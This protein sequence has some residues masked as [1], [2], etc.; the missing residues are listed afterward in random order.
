MAANFHSTINQGES[1]SECEH[2]WR[3]SLYK[4]YMKGSGYRRYVCK[5]CKEVKY[6]ERPKD[7][8]E[9]YPFEDES[10]TA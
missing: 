1:M 9:I 4:D 6:E 10:E 2:D 8:P 5:K 3:S 7:R